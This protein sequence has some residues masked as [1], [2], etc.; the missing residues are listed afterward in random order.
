MLTPDPLTGEGAST[1]AV[2][3][4]ELTAASLL[5]GR[6]TLGLAL[7][8]PLIAAIAQALDCG[9]DV[10]LVTFEQLATVLPSF[11][12][13][14]AE[15]LPTGLIDKELGA[16][17][18]F[19]VYGMLERIGSSISLIRRARQKSIVTLCVNSSRA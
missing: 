3:F 16:I 15:N 10:E 17:G 11:A 5:E 14:R 7:L 6:P 2:G 12:Y 19:L 18:I 1:L 4:V 9:G 8:P 13:G